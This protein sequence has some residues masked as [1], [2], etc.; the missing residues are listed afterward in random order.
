MPYNEFNL[1]TENMSI[2]PDMSGRMDTKKRALR[3]YGASLNKKIA[4]RY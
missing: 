2:L 4:V 3:A 1:A